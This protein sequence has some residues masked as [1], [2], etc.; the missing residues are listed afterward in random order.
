VF[1]KQSLKKHTE[2]NV[3]SYVIIRIKPTARLLHKKKR[4]QKR[5][6]QRRPSSVSIA[7]Q[8][9]QKSKQLKTPYSIIISMTMMMPLMMLL[10]TPLGRSVKQRSY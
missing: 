9:M 2:A 7:I 4:K 8:A 10:G 1:L 5:E 6:Q 3:K